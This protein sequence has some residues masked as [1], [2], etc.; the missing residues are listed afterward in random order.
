MVVCARRSHQMT[1]VPHQATCILLLGLAVPVAMR[2]LGMHSDTALHQL[3]K[4]CR[5]GSGAFAEAK[6][7]ADAGRQVLAAQR[8]KVCQTGQP[9]TGALFIHQHHKGTLI[10]ADTARATN[11]LAA[12]GRGP[13]CLYLKIS[14]MAAQHSLSAAKTE[15]RSPDHLPANIFAITVMEDQ[16]CLDCLCLVWL[17]CKSAELLLPASKQYCLRALHDLHGC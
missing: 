17:I 13:P 2:L 4:H 6:G 14:S 5:H 1:V 3:P 8:L 11:S 12:T 10:T 16:N 9:S 7:S 15:R